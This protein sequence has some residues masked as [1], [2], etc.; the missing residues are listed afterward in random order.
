M[1]N[2]S[3]S[4]ESSVTEKLRKTKTQ[5]VNLT[6]TSN[7]GEVLVGCATGRAKVGT[8]DIQ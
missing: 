8:E 3:N 4:L 6:V 7:L 1:C 2:V 5:N